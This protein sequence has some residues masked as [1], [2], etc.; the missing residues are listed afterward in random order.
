MLT[1]Y[2][3][4]LIAIVA[5][6]GGSWFGSKV[7]DKKCPDLK[8]PQPAACICPEQKPCQG[9]DFDKIKSRNIT[10]ENQQYLTIEGDSL[11]YEKIRKAVKDELNDFKVRKCR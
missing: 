10:I 6:G 5:F 11:V 8:C 2:F 4:P 1:K 7:L 9:I 3:M